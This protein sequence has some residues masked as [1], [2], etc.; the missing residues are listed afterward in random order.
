[1]KPFTRASLVVSMIASMIA[2]GPLALPASAQ[3]SLQVP[4]Q[5]DFINPGAKN[6]GMGGAFAGLADDATAT[7]VNPAGLTQLGQSEAS[8]ELRTFRVSTPF[9]QSGRLSGTISGQGIDT[10]QGAVFANSVGRDTGI[11]FAAGVF[12]APSRQWAIAAYRHELLRVD[13]SYFST[14]I[15]QKDPAELTSR[16]DSPQIGD[17]ALEVTGYGASAAYRLHR[18]L[19][20]GGSLTVYRF[21]MDSLYRR[22][23]IDGFLG[24]PVLEREFQRTS[25]VGDDTALAPTVGVMYGDA[26]RSQGRWFERMRLGVVYRRGPS[27]SYTTQGEG[28][29]AIAGLRFR[30]PHS[31]AAGASL[32]LSSPLT[33]AA[34]VTRIGYSRLV[35]DFI[36]DQARADG[37]ANDFSVSDGTEFHLGAQYA[38]PQIKG[39][40]RLRAGAWFDPDHSVK[41]TPRQASTSAFAR[42]FDER[43]A[44][45]LS[46]GGNQIHGTGGIGLTLHRRVEFNAAASVSSS[47]FRFS[48]SVIVR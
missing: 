29:P 7:F 48:S 30:V 42:V 45:A 41:F 31:L 35:E 17:R 10:E 11:G 46:R 32:R 3:S 8:V 19:S 28:V 44:T 12:L 39:R 23:D 5:F 9:L 47:Q 22:F 27:F 40:P 13:Q 24:A 43:L 25:Q 14:G 38:L 15:F 2:L 21:A 33:L 16:R 6:L 18:N 4:L 36:T 34:E 26:G 37:R 20:L 1:M